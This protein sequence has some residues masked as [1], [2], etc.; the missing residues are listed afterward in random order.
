MYAFEAVS[1]SNGVR[2]DAVVRA[3]KPV[4]VTHPGWITD[5][6]NSK[7]RGE[8]NG[9]QLSCC[10]RFLL[11]LTGGGWQAEEEDK[12]MTPV[13]AKLFVCTCW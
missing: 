1:L 3:E 7:V 12:S 11:G 8:G 6:G 4:R 13:A 5:S 9:L 2:Q 10:C